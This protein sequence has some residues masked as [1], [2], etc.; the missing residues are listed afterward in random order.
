MCKLKPYE[1]YCNEPGF[2]YHE[3]IKSEAV[4]EKAFY[5]AHHKY[6]SELPGFLSTFN[7]GE[8]HPEIV[9]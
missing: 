2:D 4:A 7:T 8:V 9:R 5:L 6:A 3:W 1:S